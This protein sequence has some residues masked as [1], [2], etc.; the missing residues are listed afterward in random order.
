MLEHVAHLEAS[1]FINMHASDRA[2]T[3]LVRHSVLCDTDIGSWEKCG[4]HCG[5]RGMS[6]SRCV[7]SE[8]DCPFRCC[9]KEV[10]YEK[11]SSKLTQR[12]DGQPLSENIL[13][14]I[15][16]RCPF[17]HLYFAERF[18]S[19]AHD[20]HFEPRLRRHAP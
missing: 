6:A 16:L 4:L 2:L 19:C 8:V 20:C 11:D 7:G 9:Y 14:L 17:F 13:S 12:F 3:F 10:E 18:D 5:G 1:R 15:I